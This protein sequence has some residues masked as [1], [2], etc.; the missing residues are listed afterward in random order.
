M[1]RSNYELFRRQAVLPGQLLLHLIQEPGGL[2][3]ADPPVHIPGPEPAVPGF[4]QVS[5]VQGQQR[6]VAL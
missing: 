3:I 6:A 2:G 5:G 1:G 4:F